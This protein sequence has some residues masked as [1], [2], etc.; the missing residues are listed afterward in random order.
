LEELESLEQAMKKKG[1]ELKLVD[2]GRLEK[3][4]AKKT[5][6]LTEE[7]KKRLDDA[8]KAQQQ[9]RREYLREKTTRFAADHL[10]ICDLRGTCPA[11]FSYALV[12]MNQ[13]EL[14]GVED[15]FKSPSNQQWNGELL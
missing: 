10:R 13:E 12:E 2:E 7:E 3:L 6:K 14:F 15:S 1:K 5:R 11:T 8:C 4:Q 9:W